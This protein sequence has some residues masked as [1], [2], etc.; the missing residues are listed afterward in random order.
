ME[1]KVAQKNNVKIKIILTK[2]DKRNYMKYSMP[3]IYVIQYL[4]PGQM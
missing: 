3:K 2:S 1:N 4:E